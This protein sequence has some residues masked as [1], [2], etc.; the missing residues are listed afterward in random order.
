MTTVHA[1]RMIEEGD[2]V[3]RT[4]RRA[5]GG[6]PVAI[7]W[8]E[9]HADAT[10]EPTVIAMAALL[11]GHPARIGRALAVATTSR[12]RQ[13]VAIA[14][15]HLRGDHQLV[16]ALARDHLVDHPDSFMVAWIAASAADAAVRGPDRP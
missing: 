16:D 14:D 15:A 1:G 11:E 5:I 9:A 2:D 7:M 6:D 4:I 10:E 12:D 3:E 13:L 8:I